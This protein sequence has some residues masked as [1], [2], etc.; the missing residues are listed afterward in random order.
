MS[1]PCINRWGLNSFWQHY[2]YSDSRYYLNL[3]HDSLVLDLL[4]TY[5]KYGNQLNPKMFY[6]IFWYKTAPKPYSQDVSMYYRWVNT[7][8]EML[9][10]ANTYRLRIENEETFRAR[11]S[12]LKFN[13]YF[14][15]NIYWFQP[16]KD[17][18]KRARLARVRKVTNVVNLLPYSKSSVI[19]LNST[20][21]LTA[22]TL[23]KPQQ[24][25]YN[26]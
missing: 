3:Q 23:S 7:Y 1:N 10:T 9:R 22:K 19:K 20:L 24:L 15:V 4:N 17:K 11:A 13:S 26:F 16:D 18:N 8:N 12:V 5:L 14:I 2:W 6:N 21:G 25:T